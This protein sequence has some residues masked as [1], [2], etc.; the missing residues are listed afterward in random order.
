STL[1]KLPTIFT[2]WLGYRPANWAPTSLPTWRVC[3]WSFLGAWIGIAL[4]EIIGLYS[5]QLQQYHSPVVIASFGA[6]AVLIYGTI[7]APL[8]QPR[9]FFFGHI[10]GALVGVIFSVLFTEL[11]TAWSSPEQETAV[12]WVTGATAMATSLVLMQLTVTVHPPG[13]ATA[14]IAVVDNTVR[15][16]RWYYIG[17][18]AMSAAVQ[19][20]VA[21]LV[22]NVEKKYPSYWWAPAKLPV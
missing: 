7:D 16:M 6:S 11:P 8:A 5:P 12:R 17:I 20:V 22:N 14:L 15:G 10:I 13:G 18:V 3:L 21:C 9:N 19:L 2:R 1:S 4:L